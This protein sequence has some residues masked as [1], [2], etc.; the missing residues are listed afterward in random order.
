MM[1]IDV[2]APRGHRR[3]RATAMILHINVIFPS[4]S[5]AFKNVPTPVPKTV[6]PSGRIGV[7]WCENSSPR[8][9]ILR[10]NLQGRVTQYDSIKNQSAE[11]RRPQFLLRGLQLHRPPIAVPTD[12]GLQRKGRHMSR[13]TM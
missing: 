5:Q 8:I 12:L 3:T 2:S 1:L 9:A 7:I 13:C 4:T 11:R 6:T 10:S